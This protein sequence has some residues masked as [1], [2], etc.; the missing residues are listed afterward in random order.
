LL[1]LNFPENTEKN[2]ESLR[3]RTAGHQTEILTRDLTNI[4][5]TSDFDSGI[6]RYF[7][8]FYCVTPWRT[9]SFYRGVRSCDNSHISKYSRAIEMRPARGSAASWIGHTS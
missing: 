6:R 3:F 7:L 5:W 1:F 8:A 9:E 2:K 4:S